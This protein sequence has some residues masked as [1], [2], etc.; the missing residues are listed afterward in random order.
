M[1]TTEYDP[2]KVLAWADSVDSLAAQPGSVRSFAVVEG[3]LIAV[4][5]STEWPAEAESELLVLAD[6]AGRPLRTLEMPMSESGDWWLG[7]AHY[8]DENGRTVVFSKN[9]RYFSPAEGCGDG[10]ADH[11]RRTVYGPDFQVISSDRRMQDGT[12]QPVDEGCGSYYNQ[13]IE[14]DFTGFEPLPT[15]DALVRVGRAPPH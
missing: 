10:V 2:A 12:G 6:P 13:F 5:D 11:R 9:V 1:R 7:L 3:R 14:G 8:F 15:Y 4:R